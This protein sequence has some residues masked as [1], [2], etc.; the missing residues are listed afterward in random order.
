MFK[1]GQLSAFYKH[2]TTNVPK[3]DNSEI[4]GKRKVFKLC[5]LV[6]RTIF[7]KVVIESIIK[8][9]KTAKYVSR[10]EINDFYCPCRKSFQFRRCGQYK[11]FFTGITT[12]NQYSLK[13]QDVFISNKT[14]QYRSQIRRH[15]LCRLIWDLHCPQRT[16][17]FSPFSS[18][19][20]F[21]Y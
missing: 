16:L 2:S 4:S 1:Y 18:L 3:I 19:S 12:I 14:G 21:C 11:F 6:C 7:I 15:V 17:N 20:R 8:L 5:M 13:V 10:T 9:S